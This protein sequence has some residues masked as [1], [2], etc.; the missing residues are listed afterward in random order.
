MNLFIKTEVRNKHDTARI[1]NK[2]TNCLTV[3]RLFMTITTKKS[4]TA[5]TSS[6][7]PAN[8]HRVNT[9]WI[10]SICLSKGWQVSRTENYEA[11]LPSY[12][13]RT[14]L[15]CTSFQ[16]PYNVILVS[17]GGYGIKTPS[18]HTWGLPQCQGLSIARAENS[19]AALPPYTIK[20]N[21]NEIIST[22]W[23]WN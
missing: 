17:Y 9:P 22:F 7:P 13:V 18:K 6:L 4:D 5:K 1:I 14:T 2:W 3:S 20:R 15:L 10:N 16:R 19:E 21:L 23:L 11:T 8:I 12:V